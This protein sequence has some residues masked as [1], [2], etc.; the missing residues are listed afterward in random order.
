M[1]YRVASIKLGKGGQAQ[2]KWAI[3]LFAMCLLEAHIR[4]LSLKETG[5]MAY[6]LINLQFLFEC[7]P[8]FL[9]H[10]LLAQK[11]SA[12]NMLFWGGAFLGYPLLLF[13]LA[14]RFDTYAQWSYFSVQGWLLCMSS[15]LLWLLMNLIGYEKTSSSS[16]IQQWGRQLFSLNGVILFGLLC[17]AFL[18]A[19]ILN[20]HQDP[21]LNQPFNLLFDIGKVFTQFSQFLMYLWQ[22]LVL[23]ATLFLVYWLNRFVL[24]RQALSQQGVLV[25]AAVVLIT[26]LVLTPILTS[27]AIAL[28]VNDLP[29]N[30]ANLT[31]GGDGNLFN[32]T[33]YQFMFLVF[34]ISTPVILAYE[35]QAQNSKLAQIEQQ[36]VKTELKFL[37]QQIQPHFLFNT[38][39]NLYALTLTKSDLAPNIVLSLSNLL[40]YTVYEGQTK[41]VSLDKEIT[42]LQNYMALYAIRTDDSIE[43]DAHWPDSP[44]DYLIAPLLLIVL[45]ENA[46]K[47]GV[48]PIKQNV[49]IGLYMR[50]EDNWLTLRCSNPLV[51]GH[52]DKKG[53]VGLENLRR[54]LAL[55]YPSKHEFYSKKEEGCWV[56]NIKL[57]L[58]PC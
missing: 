50:V 52:A 38:L 37:Q 7:I 10:V 54:R 40:R 28:P 12:K 16:F 14:E 32:K 3:P 48:E 55:L 1:K 39:N 22:M 23:A 8:L 6:I 21:M 56:A 57:E 4:F 27:I 47:H 24:I 45:L 53:G 26:I 36:K 29:A 41:A 13:I 19:G 30:V 2:V 35:R 9:A 58:T 34:A 15:S 43:F 20:T 49:K 11:V 5:A 42:C 31:P 25:Y 44:Q 17:W 18:F 51:D 46:I 33:N